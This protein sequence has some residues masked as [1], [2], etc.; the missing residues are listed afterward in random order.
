MGNAEAFVKHVVG[1]ALSSCEKDIAF[2]GAVSIIVDICLFVCLYVCVC[3]YLCMYVC[4][5]VCM[6]V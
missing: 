1:H 4:V 2:F 3:I 6:Y 5:C